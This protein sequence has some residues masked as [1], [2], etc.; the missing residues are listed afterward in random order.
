MTTKTT[1]TTETTG[2]SKLF[3]FPSEPNQIYRKEEAD[4]AETLRLVAT[5]ADGKI[6]AQ[7]VEDSNAAKDMREALVKADRIQLLMDVISEG[8]ARLQER[9][10]ITVE[11]ELLTRKSMK[12]AREELHAATRAV[13]DALRLTEAR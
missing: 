5:A 9:S 3:I 8:A 11:S 7:I 6:A 13:R 1:K 10:R 2:P 12:E 4:K